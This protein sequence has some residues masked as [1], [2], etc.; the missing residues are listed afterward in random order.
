MLKAE[1]AHFDTEAFSHG[2]ICAS[3]AEQITNLTNYLE[4]EAARQEDRNYLNELPS[5]KKPYASTK[6]KD[7]R[8]KKTKPGP[9]DQVPKGESSSTHAAPAKSSLTKAKTK[10]AA[11]KPK[12]RSTKETSKVKEKAKTPPASSS[13]SAKGKSK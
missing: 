11:L 3:I 1:A 8:P 12:T 5:S 9:E 2:I 13:G 4:Q 6:M 10:A 7:T